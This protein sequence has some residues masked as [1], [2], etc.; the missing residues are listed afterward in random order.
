MAQYIG[1]C[2]K[3]EFVEGNA[4]LGV[5]NIERLVARCEAFTNPEGALFMA[6]MAYDN[7]SDMDNDA[8]V[9]ENMD[10]IIDSLVNAF[11]FELK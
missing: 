5:Q 2:T 6:G 11:G 9:I 3:A 4:H 1:K 8:E 7:V 10:S